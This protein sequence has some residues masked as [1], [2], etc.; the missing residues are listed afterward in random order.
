MIHPTAVI[1]P[2]AHLGAD[3]EIG[4]YTVVAGP[5][6]IG[7]RGR[8]GPHCHLS[9]HTRIGADAEIHAGAI[10]GDLP[11][12]KH[13]EG[14][15]TG[16]VIGDGCIIREYVTIHRGTQPDTDTIIGNG[17]MLMAYSHVAHNCILGDNVVIANLAQLAGHVEIGDR[18]FLS[19]GVMVHQFVRIGSL[20][21]ATGGARIGRDVP[22]YCMVDVNGRVRGPNVVGLRR[23]GMEGITRKAIKDAMHTYFF[24]DLQPADALAKLQAR[25]DVPEE[26]AAFI[27]FFGPSKRGITTAHRRMADEE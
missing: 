23:A 25:D 4:P 22:P 10:V 5:V 26:V 24:S 21:M 14:G 7:D 16:V 8:I 11:Q 18:A 2:A 3:V 13:F 15:D 12:D 19:A 1:D 6:Q 9:G 17:V 20:V 27:A